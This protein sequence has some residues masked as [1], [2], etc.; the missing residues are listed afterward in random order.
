MASLTGMLPNLAANGI[1]DCW[2]SNVVAEAQAGP[3]PR[4]NK[5]SDYRPDHD[6]FPYWEYHTLQVHV[7]RNP[8]YDILLGRPFDVLTQA[9]GD[10]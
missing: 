9:P 5:C 6:P 7:V 10:Y 3:R 8:A 1:V 4:E 2:C